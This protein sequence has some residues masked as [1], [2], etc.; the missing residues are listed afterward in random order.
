MRGSKPLRLYFKHLREHWNVGMC[1]GQG[2][3][4]CFILPV[5]STFDCS[6]GNSLEE[7][8]KEP[9]RREVKGPG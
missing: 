5:V 2:W 6:A 1:F 9:S 7:A 8:G 3:G 4:V